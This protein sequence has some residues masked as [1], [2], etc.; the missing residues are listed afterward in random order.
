MATYAIKSCNLCGIRKPQPEMERVEKEVVT[1]SSKSKITTGNVLGYAMGNK[2]SQNKVHR[3][4]FA[5]N[6][7]Q[8][9]RKR[10]VWSCFECSG[11]NDRIRA[12]QARAE[13]KAAPTEDNF[14]LPA[15]SGN[16][17]LKI[18]GWVFLGLTVVGII[19][20]MAGL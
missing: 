18:I 12:E 17:A 10:T 8:Y 2:M 20:D 16:I 13:K 14:T 4:I 3:N 15:N 6:K 7:R 11:R 9:K 5:N 1:G 19:A